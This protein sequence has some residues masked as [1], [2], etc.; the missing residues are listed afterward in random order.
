MDRDV[1]WLKGCLS[2]VLERAVSRSDEGA[3]VA[4]TCSVATLRSALLLYWPESRWL[5]PL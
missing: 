1:A 5:L 2:G 4:R 3:T